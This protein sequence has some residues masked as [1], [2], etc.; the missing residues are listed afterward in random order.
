MIFSNKATTNNVQEYRE[1]CKYCKGPLG[2]KEKIAHNSCCEEFV[3]DI[4]EESMIEQI[5]D[6]ILKSLHARSSMKLNNEIQRKII[7][8]F[9]KAAPDYDHGCFLV[10]EIHKGIPE[11][12]LLSIKKN[13]QVLTKKGIIFIPKKFPHT[14]YRYLS[15]NLL[16]KDFDE[17]NNIKQLYYSSIDAT[18]TKIY[19]GIDTW[20]TIKI[21][22]LKEKKYRLERNKKVKKP[23][24]LELHDKLLLIN[25]NGIVSC[26][27]KGHENVRHEIEEHGCSKCIEEYINDHF[28]TWACPKCSKIGTLELSSRWSN[29]LS[30]IIKLKSI[31]CNVSIIFENEDINSDIISLQNKTSNYNEIYL[32][33]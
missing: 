27:N 8:F 15:V 33:E 11:A 18:K 25:N 7:T 20:D 1:Y 31:C 4:S 26:Q 19:P 24:L 30:K 14:Y 22:L 10:E 12:S 21:R 5:D 16:E 2:K 6:L 13:L 23:L 28:R 32:D 17:I 9:I 29:E 3:A